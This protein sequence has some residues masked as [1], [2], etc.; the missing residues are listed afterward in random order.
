[1][2]TQEMPI[3]AMAD[4]LK[5]KTGLEGYSI[6]YLKADLDDLEDLC[7]LQDLETRGIQGDSIVLLSRDKHSFMNTYSIILQYAEKNPE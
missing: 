3:P 7:R 2:L 5:N 1:M 6:K 4:R